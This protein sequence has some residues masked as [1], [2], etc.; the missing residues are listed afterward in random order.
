MPN[1]IETLTG[2]FT[3]KVPVERLL[4]MALGVGGTLL[5]IL[6]ILLVAFLL[7]KASNALIDRLIAQR[8]SE[9]R[10]LIDDRKARTLRSLLKSVT[11]YVIYVFA[12]ISILSELGVNTASLLAGAGLA[13]IAIGFGAQN[14][15][16]DIINGFFIL[17]EDQFAVGDYVAIGDVS[18]IVEA[19]GLR[20]THVR[21]FGGE[22]HVIPN[23]QISKVTNH[24]GSAMRVMFSVAVGYEADIDRAIEA[25]ARDFEKAREEIAGIVEGPTVLG[26]NALSESG[27]ELLI[28]AKTKAME[29]WRVERELKKRVKDVLDREGIAIP[30]PHMQVILDNHLEARQGS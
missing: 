13:G 19:I 22:L 17:F 10:K 26:V 5:R 24:M 20:V 21:G 4:D 11:R 18:G 6:L 2:A 23:G 7:V 15:V 28:I 27:V 9:D 25:L 12:G 3:G 29:Q 14:L 16:R 1:I 30:Y 8:A